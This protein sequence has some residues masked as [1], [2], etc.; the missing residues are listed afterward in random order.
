MWS[1]AMCVHTTFKKGQIIY[2]IWISLT[3]LSRDKLEHMH[4]A[5]LHSTPQVPYILRLDK[6][7]FVFQ[8]LICDFKYLN[9]KGFSRDKSFVRPYVNIFRFPNYF[10]VNNP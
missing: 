5:P 1:G 9:S 4:M 3:T 6:S 10:V 7:F 2:I 8:N